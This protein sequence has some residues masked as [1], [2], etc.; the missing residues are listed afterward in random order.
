MKKAIPSG[1]NLLS[2]AFGKRKI[3]L[4]H[5]YMKMKMP[6][7]LKEMGGQRA[8]GVVSCAAAKLVSELPVEKCQHLEQEAK[9]VSKPQL[10]QCYM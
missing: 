5:I 7:I 6:A 2:A 8:I 1:S 9:E 10:G 3:S 4:T